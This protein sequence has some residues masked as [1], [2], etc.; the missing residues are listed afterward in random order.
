MIKYIIE[1]LKLQSS[2]ILPGFGS[3]QVANTKTGKIVFNP[4]LKFNDGTLAKYIAQKEGIDQQAAQN[5]V[6]KFIREIEAEVS[7][8]NSFDM[9]Q[10]GKFLKNKKGDIE[11]I[12]EGTPVEPVGDAK[13]PAVKKVEEAKVEKK[14]DAQK[15]EPKAEK[16]AEVKKE[17]PKVE[18]KAE[19]KKEEPKVEKKAELK[20]EEPKPEKKPEVKKDEA[21][22]EKPL[23]K[24][25]ELKPDPSPE[26]KKDGKPVPES[27]PVK[28]H[29]IPED[30]SKIE[31]DSKQNKN[32]FTPKEELSKTS[33]IAKAA[34]DKASDK[35]EPKIPEVAK[36]IP[37]AEATKKDP[38]AQE[39]NK[40]VPPVDGAKGSPEKTEKIPDVAKETPKVMAASVHDER[41]IKENGS[42]GTKEKFKKDKPQKV[43]NE[44]P[45]EKKKKRWVRWVVILIILGGGAAAGWMYKDQ[46]KG[47]LYA[48]VNDKD[49]TA[50]HSDKDSLLVH[51][52]D[53]N[54]EGL[55]TLSEEV[56]TEEPVVEET[57]QNEEPVVEEPDPQPEPVTHNT[58][59]TSSS[60]N[61]HI[62]GNSFSSEQNANNYAEKMSGKGYPAKVLGK[63]DNLYLVSIKSFSSRDEAKS[64]LSSVSADA[65]SGWVFKY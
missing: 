11:F 20:K 24:K 59:H 45:K 47:F 23:E 5:Q 1:I 30:K 28:K 13:K 51:N 60:G 21:I 63:F 4:L 15:D 54:E 16:K 49:S 33:D 48:G 41:E 61:Y 38:A 18:K 53:L 3:L 19:V 27:E 39:K 35:P 42:G 17:E 8:G 14:A 22:V 43:K 10:F 55:D 58:N 34:S 65:P 7:K 44:V 32:S 40:F 31:A 12:Q 62:I 57:D 6:A 46:I 9:F 64:G 37:L 50:T 26:V 56:I 52:T 2:V 36:T 25:V 29:G